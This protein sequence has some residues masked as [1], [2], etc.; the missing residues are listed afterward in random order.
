[1]PNSMLPDRLRQVGEDNAEVVFAPPLF[2]LVPLALG[3]LLGY[4]APVPLG[5]PW[6]SALPALALIGSAFV[7]FGWAM[8]TL[9]AKGTTHLPA[10]PTAAIVAEGPYAVT[11]NPI[12][13]AMALMYL[14]I[15]LLAGLAWALAL[16]PVAVAGVRWGAIARE[17]R[18]LERKFGDAYL[19]YKGRVRRWV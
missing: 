2:F 19:A 14:G 1:M 12:Y 6:W 9:H 7:L 3:W 15:A 8:R 11:R 16:F 4:V 17:E 13:L 10:R 5:L 18:Y